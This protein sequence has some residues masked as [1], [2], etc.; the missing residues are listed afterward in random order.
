MRSNI[1]SFA[2]TIVSVVT[3]RGAAPVAVLR[4][5][6]SLAQTIVREM[7]GMGFEAEMPTHKMLRRAILNGE[8]R[9]L[10]DALVVLMRAPNSFTGEDVV[11][12]HIHGSEPVVHQVL[13]RSCALGARQAGPGEFSLRAVLNGRMNVA[14]AEAIADL[15]S[16]G[17]TS[18]ALSAAA[19]VRGALSKRIGD[20]LARLESVLI[21]WRAA[22][23]F[24]DYPTG[25]GATEAHW[26]VL[27]D[28][29]DV[30]SALLAAGRPALSGAFRVA[31]CGAPNVG[32]STLLNRLAGS[33]RVL[34]DA[35][36]GTTRD[37]VEIT[38]EIAGTL[39]SVW[40]TAG[41]RDDAEALESRGIEMSLA[42]ALES[43]VAFWIIDPQEPIW[44]DG[45][46]KQAPL[47]VVMGKADLADLE[48]AERLKKCAYERGLSWAGVISGLNGDGIDELM[49]S[50]MDQL[51]ICDDTP[52]LRRRHFGLIKHAHVHVLQVLASESLPLDM[53]ARDLEEALHALG[54][55]LGRDVEM[56]IFE[57]IFSEFCIGK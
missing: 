29:A 15:I 30:L 55:I 34:V 12:F 36:P 10:D 26:Q 23:D 24:P 44:P 2:D 9:V 8:G 21:D 20:L 40:D 16:A 51:R 31:L 22:L 19:N 11:E 14:Q 27:S 4:L 48:C 49:T 50:S 41:I 33:E 3:A 18:Q 6:G 38:L 7:T 17:S 5:S 32:K 25:D 56:S 54:S 45:I 28:V 39:F 35:I 46:W 13:E 53:M 37:P 43:D 47:A 52:H 42:R 57:G 1:E